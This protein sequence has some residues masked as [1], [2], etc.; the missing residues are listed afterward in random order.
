M[1]H[2]LCF[3]FSVDLRFQ[4]L[5]NYAFLFLL[6]K[7]VKA[8]FLIT[9]PPCISKHSM[10]RG[11]CYFYFVIGLFTLQNG[12]FL[13]ITINHS[14]LTNVISFWFRSIHKLR[15]Y[16]GVGRWWKMSKT[17]VICEIIIGFAD[18]TWQTMLQFNDVQLYMGIT[19]CKLGWAQWNLS[20]FEF[21]FDDTRL[22]S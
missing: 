10:L 6:T 17:Y 20:S 9:S 11:T 18:T 1:D 2:I 19:V 3:S 13:M 15:K 8:F 12:L 14:L 4:G 16:L 21:K 7:G 5:L 22:S